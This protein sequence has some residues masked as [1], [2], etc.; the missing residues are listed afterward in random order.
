MSKT[1]REC[2][3]DQQLLLPP[4]L[5]EWL[6]EGH[7]ALFIS[8]MVDALDLSAIL[9]TYETGDARGQPPFH[10]RMMTKLLIYA[11]CKG[12]PS[13]RKIEQ[14]TYDEVPCRV[15]TAGQ[16]PDHDT[17]SEFRRRHLGALAGLFMQVLK[18]CREAGLVK[19]GHVALDGTKVKANASKHKAMSYDRM[20][21]KEKQLEQE[22]AR[23]LKE[24]EATDTAEDA[25]YGKGKRGDELPPEWARRDSRLKKIKEAKAAL[26]A[27]ARELAAAKAEEV[28]QKLAERAKQEE[29]GRKPKGPAPQMPDVEKALPRAEAQ[30]NFT[31]PESRIMKDGASKTFEQCYNVQAAVDSTAQVIVA[32]GVTQ[33][34]NDKQQLVPMLKKVE[35]NMQRLP[36]AASADAG[37]FSDEAVS[38]PVLGK[39]DLHVPPDRQKHGSENVPDAA[40]GQT[41]LIA[42]GKRRKKS[43]PQ[44]ESAKQMREKLKAAAG[45]A[46]YKM[47][48][49]I[50]EPVFGQIK[51][52]RGFRRF[53]FRGLEK[54]SAEW[55]LIALTHNLLKLFK[56]RTA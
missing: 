3:L 29:S 2:D 23:L 55:T 22:V 31:D 17:I 43:K 49:A 14:A 25:A 39:V 11:Y 44:S 34:M 51:E 1:F 7:L 40:T 37:Y 52:R 16:H 36:E 19:L 10:P 48:K 45:H 50:V 42:A 54:V 30:R 47:R 20:C 24:A 35:E 8:D 4:N 18:M 27:E 15:L 38:D 9:E 32:V 13:S 28:K 46:L 12:K 41:V 21:E 33:Q 56:A 6:P 53:S 26:E 5:R